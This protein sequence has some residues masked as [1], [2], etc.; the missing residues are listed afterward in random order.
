MLL[1]ACVW[2]GAASALSAEGH[3]VVWAGDWDEDPGDHEIL[4]RAHGEKRVLVTL[5]KD[6]G[7]LA[8]VREIPHSGIVRLVGFA[9][10]QQARICMTIL[11]RYGPELLSGALVTVQPG[12][13]RIR[14]AGG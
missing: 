11:D 5:D 10:R 3:D 2:G 14:R 7:E 9:A 8:I 6:F 4:R 1:D 13:V 12:R